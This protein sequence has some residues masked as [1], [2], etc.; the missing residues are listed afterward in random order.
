MKLVHFISRNQIQ[1]D[2]A[3]YAYIRAELREEQFDIDRMILWGYNP[4]T[5][6]IWFGQ[7]KFGRG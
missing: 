5:K 3:P 7:E 1:H 6:Q 2:P 4:K